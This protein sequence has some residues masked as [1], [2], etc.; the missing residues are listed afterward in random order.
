MQ[1][2]FDFKIAGVHIDSHLL[3]EILAYII[4]YRYYIYLRSGCQDKIH[5]KNRIAII[6][7]AAVGAL[8]LSKVLGVLEHPQFF[9]LPFS[10]KILFFMSTKTIVG[11][12]LGG[13][14]GVEWTKKII[15][16]KNS[17]GDLFCFPIILGMI[18]G[19]IGCFLSGIEDGT[20]GI[21]TTFF[22]GMDL[23]DG[24]RRHPTALYEIFVLLSIWGTLLIVRR[25]K[26]L[27]DGFLFELF[28]IFYLGWRLFIEFFKPVYYYESLGVSAIQM[29]C[30]CGLL[31]YLY[32]QFSFTKQKTN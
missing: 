2:P 26:S 3:F 6:V 5:S 24:L 14:I 30:I 9:T 16:E 4:A 22:L 7:G 28:M 13:L 29:A 15:G 11:G 8:V 17:S 1:L 20:H 19:R 10:K 32:K 18:V 23:G 27:R 25:E 12:L 31:Y 21:E